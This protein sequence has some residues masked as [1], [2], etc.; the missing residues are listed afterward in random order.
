M[1]ISMATS[2]TSLGAN[3]GPT[4]YTL[5]GKPDQGAMTIGR[6]GDG[7]DIDVDID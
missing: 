4:H 5:D 1:T 6:G 3:A 7:P 2:G